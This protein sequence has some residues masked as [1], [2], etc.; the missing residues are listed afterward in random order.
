MLSKSKIKLLKSLS[1]KKAREKEGMFLVEGWRAVEEA[2]ASLNEIPL[3][4]F[5]TDSKKN[6]SYASILSA[7]KKISRESYEA[8]A[9]EFDLFADTVTAQGIAAVVRTFSNDQEKV[10]NRLTKNGRSFVLALDEITD[11]GNLGT[12]IRTCDWFGADGILLSRNCV[13]L[14][15]PKVVRSTVGS[16]FRLPCIDCSKSERLFPEA[17]MKLKKAGFV[18]YGAEVSGSNDLRSLSWPEKAVLVV[19]NEA[20]GISPEI[21]AILDHH[22]AIPRFGKAESLNAGTAVGIFLSHYSFQKRS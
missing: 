22:V 8:S 10:L 17:L 20:R 19:G 5:A 14:Y 18:L 1:Q 2:C 4:V 16:I 15:N 13:E 6:E 21:K 11:P 7:A 3:L 12:I 9:K